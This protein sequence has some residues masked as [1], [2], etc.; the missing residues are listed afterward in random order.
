LVPAFTSVHIFRGR[1]RG[2]GGDGGMAVF[3]GLVWLAFC[4]MGLYPGGGLKTF[5][6]MP[7][8]GLWFL[9][10]PLIILGVHI[11]MWTY[12]RHLEGLTGP[13]IASELSR[14]DKSQ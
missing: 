3:S 8:S 6:V 4:Q 1:Y 7:M 12:R 2:S 13:W 5:E 11:F 14:N 9:L 10:L